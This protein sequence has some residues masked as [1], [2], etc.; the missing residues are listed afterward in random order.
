MPTDNM[1]PFMKAM[2]ATDLRPASPVT[3]ETYPEYDDQL[4]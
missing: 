3:Q 2:L 1:S 4:L